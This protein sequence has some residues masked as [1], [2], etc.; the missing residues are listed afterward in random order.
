MHLNTIDNNLFFKSEKTETRHGCEK[1]KGN[2]NYNVDIIE[3]LW[4]QK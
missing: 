3:F 2:Y 1:R 4:D